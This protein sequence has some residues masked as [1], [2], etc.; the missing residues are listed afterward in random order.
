MDNPMAAFVAL[1]TQN[2]RSAMAQAAPAPAPASSS[3]IATRNPWRAGSGGGDRRGGG[4]KFYVRGWWSESRQLP[5]A[6]GRIFYGFWH[7]LKSQIQL[8]CKPRYKGFRSIREAAMFDGFTFMVPFEAD[9]AVRAMPGAAEFTKP[10][11]MAEKEL[12]PPV[13]GGSEDARDTASLTRVVPPSA[14]KRQRLNLRGD[15]SFSTCAPRWRLDF[16]LEAV[17]SRGLPV[18]DVPDTL[19]IAT[20]GSVL[21]MN[22]EPGACG[23]IGIAWQWGDNCETQGSFQKPMPWNNGGHLLGTRHT[24]ISAEWKAIIEAM[25][26]VAFKFHDSRSGD[27]RDLRKGIHLHFFI[28]CKA[29]LTWLQAFEKKLPLAGPPTL[30]SPTQTNWALKSRASMMLQSILHPHFASVSFHWVKAHRSDK[31]ILSLQGI[32][33]IAA[34]LNR[35]ADQSAKTAA[36]LYHS[37][38]GDNTRSMAGVMM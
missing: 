38:F 20:D 15:D 26:L 28:D 2:A 8:P 35:A 29:V 10:L 23:G 14:R 3:T 7:E 21:G 34:E 27:G 16:P 18:D 17:W 25:N 13:F 1:A 30:V 32:D 22:G 36:T 6:K 31:A 12:K 5:C 4:R 33:K 37:T 19:L 11:S 9:D 24:N